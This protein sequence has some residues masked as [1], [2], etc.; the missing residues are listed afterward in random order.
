MGTAPD[1]SAARATYDRHRPHRVLL[2]AHI[3]DVP[4]SCAHIKH[5]CNRRGRPS[6]HQ[7]NQVHPAGCTPLRRRGRFI[8]LL[9]LTVPEVELPSALRV[10]E[11]NL[12]HSE[13]VGI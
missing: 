8:G 10:I 5:G 6:C 3:T 11:A 13:V 12:A 2:G 9:C 7:I 4:I 1:Q